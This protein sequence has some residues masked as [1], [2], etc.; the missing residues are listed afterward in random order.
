MLTRCFIGE[1]K[2]ITIELQKF[3]GKLRDTV[4]IKK[5]SPY[6]PLIALNGLKRPLSMKNSNAHYYNIAKAQELGAF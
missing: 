1:C 4:Q 3:G 2:R 5:T 6:V